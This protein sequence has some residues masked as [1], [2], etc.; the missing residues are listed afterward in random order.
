MRHLNSN[1][2]IGMA[3]MALAFVQT[4][5]VAKPE[6]PQWYLDG[7]IYQIF[8]DRFF[9]GD[10]SNNIKSGAYEYAGNKSIEK[11]W[12]ESPLPEAGK[13]PAFTFYGGDLAGIQQKMPYI[14]QRLGANILYLNPIFE[15]P[16][17]HKYDTS[18]YFKVAKCLGSENDLLSLSKAIHSS[19]NAKSHLILDAV[20][21]HTGD[22]HKWFHK[23]NFANSPATE[24]GAFESKQSKYSS[25]YTFSKWPTKYASFL[26][27]DSLPKLDFGS[28]AVKDIIYRNDDSVAQHYLK[29][30]FA[31]DGW[32]VDAPQYID[33][34]GKQGLDKFNHEIWQDFRKYVKAAKP[35][36]VILGEFWHDA[37]SWTNSGTEWDTVTNFEGF[38]DPVSQW[39]CGVNYDGKPKKIKASE[40]EQQLRKTR[41]HYPFE[42]QQALSN[43]L[44]NHDISRFAERAA[45]DLRKSRLAFLFQMTYVGVPTIY[46]GDEYGM[47]GGKDPD[48]RRTF[49]WNKI[50][51]NKDLVNYVH[52]LIKLRYSHKSLR[53]GEFI[54]L[55]TFDDKN[56]L[57]FARRSKA[58][59]AIVALNASD[60]QQ[61]F[62]I[63]AAKANFADGSEFIDPL[64]GSKYK[65]ANGKLNLSVNPMDGCILLQKTN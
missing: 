13:S 12:G 38:T 54:T 53:S 43:H 26:T 19:E 5:A 55:D 44:S 56:G 17:N 36:S 15:S 29:E 49:D 4:A 51:S 42:V 31:I 48:C 41:Q 59:S 34:N 39:I 23:Y 7:V 32:R 64:T 61:S 25:F 9:D 8:P 3:L 21:N 46:Y 33:K 45:G 52:D 30:P 28:D 62:S 24:P 6:I 22:G 18:D 65:V 10:S 60:S 2:I 50:E 20:F 40:F 57:C 27:Y 16:S 35:D 58:D 47:M 14:T 1:K 63:S 37:S 11:K